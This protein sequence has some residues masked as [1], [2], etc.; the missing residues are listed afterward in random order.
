MTEKELFEEFGVRIEIYED[1]L[2]K[3]EAFYIPGLQTMFLSN[4]IPESKRVQVT[5]HEL[6]HKGH[7][8][9]L[10]KIFREK[11]ELEANRNMIHYLMKEELEQAEDRTVFNYL[12]FM[13]K[14]NLKTIADETMVLEEYYNLV[15]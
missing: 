1:Y 13:E 9:H 7:M 15:G 3:D 14:Y 8:P 5:L 2:F 11:C 4:A 6:G 10:Y 12:V